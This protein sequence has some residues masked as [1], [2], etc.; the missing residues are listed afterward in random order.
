M[1][2]S[3]FIPVLA[4]AVLVAGSAEFHTAAALSAQAQV[5]VRGHAAVRGTVGRAG[6]HVP[7]RE[8]LTEVVPR[9][10]SINMPNAGAWVDTPV[11]WGAHRPFV[12]ALK[13]MLSGAPGLVADVDTDLRLVT[14]RQRSAAFDAPRAAADYA[15]AAPA[16][17]RA[18]PELPLSAGPSDSDAQAHST[19]AADALMAQRPPL[20]S[21][22]AAGDTGGNVA[23]GA[24]RRARTAAIDETKES[25][26][27]SVATSQPKAGARSPVAA[28]A[29]LLSA[30]RAPASTYTQAP[31]QTYA[32]APIAAPAVAP[33]IAQAPAPVVTPAIAEA[34]APVVAPAIAPAPTMVEAAPA[35]APVAV[36]SEPLARDWRITPD[37]HTVKSAL[38]R[39]ANEAGWQFVWDVPT[40]FAIEASATVHG[41]MEDALN[42]VVQALSRSQVPIQVILYKGNKVLRVV[43]QGAA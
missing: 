40:D 2:H 12:D 22:H 11:T 32:P 42:A 14:I 13:E 36:Q 30:A 5:T 10:Y 19:Q 37:D 31:A 1:R 3:T 26:A 35:A 27:A 25:R 28:Q 41:T 20:L 21:W 34:P 8:A 9:A 38:A 4:F 23:A 33:T 7:L 24:E 29:P 6:R 16:P 15:A 18:S 39:W 43:G 17:M